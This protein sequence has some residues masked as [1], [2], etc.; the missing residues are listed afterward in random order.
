MEK[1]LS[2]NETAE[3][4]G[5]SERRV[6]QYCSEG[7]IPG[8]Q[9][10]GKAW[11]V[12]YDAEKPADPRRERKGKSSAVSEEIHGGEPKAELPGIDQGCL[13]PLMNTAFRPGSAL[14]AVNAMKEGAQRDIAMAEYHYFSG[15]PEKA[16]MEAEA[17][18][19]S[20]GMGS[21]L[22]AYLIYTYANLSLGRIQKAREGLDAINAFLSAA[23]KQSP[24]LRTAAAFIASAGAVL[25]HLPL[26]DELPDTKELMVLLPAGLRAFA[27]YVQAHYLYLKGEYARSA[28]MVEA[29]LAM[30]AVAYPIPAIYLHL[31]AIMDHMSLK[32]T[33]EAERHLLSAW[34]LARPDDLIEGFGE[35]HGLLGGMLEAVIKPGWPEDFKRMIEI[36]YRFSSGWRRVHNPI[37]GNDVADDL[38]TTEF[39]VAMLASRGW[40]NQEIAE[41]LNVS[42]NTVKKHLLGAMRKLQV[43]N[44]RDLKKYMLK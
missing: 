10:V 30:G 1:Y 22:S 8:A 2:T 35:H 25:L 17:Y 9:R 26:P 40:T 20:E 18:L 12:P 29:A 7:R 43:E 27:L 21:R 34:E 5:V 19:D 42:A 13:M 3:K 24:E 31:V 23:G 16:A 14:P 11:A 37:T 32:Q 6:G 28:G 38:T 4:W 44:R 15:Q 39:A 36:T 33:E 41:Q